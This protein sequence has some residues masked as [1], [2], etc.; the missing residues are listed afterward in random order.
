[1]VNKPY[2]SEDAD[3]LTRGICPCEY[4]RL[5]ITELKT[6]TEL[7]DI[8][9]NLLGIRLAVLRAAGPGGARAIVL[10]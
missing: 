4:S 3:R 5:V 6:V 9:T 8:P 2:M 10:R 1:M 7:G